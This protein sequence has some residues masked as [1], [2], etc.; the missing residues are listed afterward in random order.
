M[1]LWLSFWSKS[2]QSSCGGQTLDGKLRFVLLQVRVGQPQPWLSP[3][4]RSPA[5]LPR[6]SL[7]AAFSLNLPW[8]S[9]FSMVPAQRRLHAA[10]TDGSK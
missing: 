4:L 8:W 3:V 10:L 2:V 5:T 7:V 6:P 9:D 1:T